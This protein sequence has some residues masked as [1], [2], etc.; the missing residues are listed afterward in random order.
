M[1]Q[2]KPT[3]SI[4]VVFSVVYTTFKNTIRRRKLL[5]GILV[6]ILYVVATTLIFQ[7]KTKTLAEFN[8]PRISFKYPKYYQE[9]PKLDPAKNQ[10]KNLIKLKSV[11]PVSFIILAE[12]KNAIRGANLLK[13]NFLDFL[14][15]NAER[16]FPIVY[17]DYQKQKTERIK[18][19]ERDASFMS[20]SYTGTDN[21]TTVYVNFFIIPLNN[22][23]Y[24]LTIQS[25][26]E[27][28][29]D[30]DTEKVQPT[31]EIK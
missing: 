4:G 8:S 25:P 28:R 22:D 6:V 2:P 30:S 14:E 1:S 17:D 13:T 21:K 9:Q 19:S 24:Y 12:E 10:A 20:F 15:R 23:A 5:V 18:I 26:D 7:Q 31:I 27:S 3:S 29:L 11:D 16:K